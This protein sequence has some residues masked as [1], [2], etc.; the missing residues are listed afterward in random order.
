MLGALSET[1]VIEAFTRD[2]AEIATSTPEELRE[3]MVADYANP[4]R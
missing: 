1:S 2:G 4:A 3:I